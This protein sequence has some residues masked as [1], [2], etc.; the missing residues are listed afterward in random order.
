[1]ANEQNIPIE[2]KQVIFTNVNVLAIPEHVPSNELKKS[3][4][5]LNN[6][7]NIEL[8]NEELQEYAVSMTS[9]FNL[10]KDP[11]APYSIDI[12]CIGI[13]GVTDSKATK[14]EVMKAMAI[15]GHSIVYGAIR[16]T[17]A[18][19]T[20]RSIFGPFTFGISVLKPKPEEKI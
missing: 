12:S 2:L 5:S 18:W 4:A 16:E 19:I 14:D 11:S 3:E 1:M 6:S 7:I 17:V 20:S 8:L 10:I 13:F 9:Q 15:I